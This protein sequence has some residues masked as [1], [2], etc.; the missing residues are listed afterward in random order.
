MKRMLILFALVV[1]AVV[2][3]TGCRRRSRN[4]T[5]EV[6][7]TAMVPGP[8]ATGP[9]VR[10]ADGIVQILTGD[11]DGEVDDMTEDRVYSAIQRGD[12]DDPIDF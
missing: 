10:P 7:K 8:P 1:V 3:T 9:V 12:N 5:T 11:P 4:S 2:L 6:E